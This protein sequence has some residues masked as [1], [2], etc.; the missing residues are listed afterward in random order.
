ME[1][2]YLKDLIEWNNDPYRKPLIV[3][4]SRQ[5]GKTYLIRD[6]FAERYYSGKYIYID[7]NDNPDFSNYCETHSS[8]DILNY[9]SLKTGKDIDQ[10]TLLIFDEAQECPR[11]ITMM[12]YFCQ[13]HRE[14]PIVVTGSMVRIRIKR[15]KRGTNEKGFLFPVGKINEITI[16]PLSFDEY[17]YNRN[18][19]IY[20]TVVEHYREKKPMDNVF[21][22]MAM[23][24]F[25]EY[26]LIGGM[27]ESV[28]TF[29]DTENFQKSRKIL[30]QLY[31]NY[32]G[33]MELYQASPESVIRA[34]AIFSNIYTLLNRESKNFSPGVIEK[35]ARTRD[36]LSPLDW[37]NEAHVVNICSRIEGHVTL[38]LIS[39]DNTFR[40]Y[41]CDIGM[42]SY[43]SPIDPTSF[44]TDDGRNM[45]A[46]IFYETFAAQELKSRGLDLFYWQGKRNAEFE[47][48][49]G[50]KNVAIPIDVKKGRGSMNS[51]KTYREINS[52]DY[53][54]KVSRNNYGFD[55]EQ[56]I[57]TIPF[58]EL[59]LFADEMADDRIPE[60]I[61]ERA[62]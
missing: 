32:L 28:S 18:R 45:L 11:I 14:I 29:L 21:H 25:Y 56:R 17:L 36:M 53:A 51:L 60:G 49:L 40:L 52:L 5:V 54:V 57:L 10:S 39:T 16:T 2:R 35:G 43:Q 3:W 27:P 4:G 31:D 33:D 26:L 44:I 37:L 46:G 24:T 8:D 22:E 23:K 47:F 7:F 9:L 6:I 20:D 15:K 13:D 55:E 34:R 48:I 30:K 59:F 62:I 50:R 58:Y 19:I 12:K 38:P 41:L 1:R 42:F 61:L